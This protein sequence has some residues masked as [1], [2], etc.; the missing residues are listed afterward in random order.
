T[1]QGLHSK[2]NTP[3]EN[4]LTYD[5][6]E[7]NKMVL[8]SDEAH[9]INAET[10][11]GKDLS[12]DDIENIAS[13]EATITR[14]FNANPENVMLEFTATADLSNPDIARKYDHKL[15]F[16]YPLRQFR[17]DGYSKDV[18]TLQADLPSF[19]RALQAILL[20]QYRRKLF[21][22]QGLF[23]KPVILFKS[24]TIKESNVFQ[25]EFTKQ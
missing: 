23:I 10:K 14:I 15:L 17:A 8:I 7:S 24:K 2:L 6:F 4:A 22:K 18:Q 25:E 13:W 19:D 5:D 11:K 21:E 12:T 20:S 16:D 9:H 1:V 3:R